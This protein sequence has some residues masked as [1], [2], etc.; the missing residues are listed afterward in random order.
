MK[1]VIL[2][3]SREQVNRHIAKR[4]DSLGISY[5]TKKLDYA[6]YSFEVDGISYENKI[7]I[8]RKHSIDELIGNFTKGRERFQREFE[9]AKGCKVILMVEA[10][11][12][13]IDRHEYRSR[14]SP[15]DIR[16]FLKNMVL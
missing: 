1:G 3:D 9:R 13:Q 14:M 7:V 15:A 10:S 11:E 2:I 5:K 16:S 4:L 6:D 8:E 12:S